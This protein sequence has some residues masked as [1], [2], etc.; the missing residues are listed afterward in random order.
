MSHQTLTHPGTSRVH[1]FPFSPPSN[2]QP[3]STLT[4]PAPRQIPSASA[5]SYPLAVRNPRDPVPFASSD[6][7]SSPSRSL[8]L[9][10]CLL[11]PV[12]P[13]PNPFSS[14]PSD[15]SFLALAKTLPTSPATVSALAAHQQQQPWVYPTTR[16]KFL[17]AGVPMPT[18][19]IY[20]SH[21]RNAPTS[22]PAY[23]P[24]YKPS[25]APRLLQTQLQFLPLLLIGFFRSSLTFSPFCLSDSS[26]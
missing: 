20:A 6:I 22:P 8:H 1:Q 16:S 5:F 9:A 7:S 26:D 10:R 2:T 14:I 24:N 18:S 12:V 13:S 23:H 17:A 3:V 15:P 11:Y 25:S 19:L 4:F 21:S